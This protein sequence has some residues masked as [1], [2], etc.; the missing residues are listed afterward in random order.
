MQPVMPPGNRA[1]AWDGTDQTTALLFAVTCSVI[2]GHSDHEDN[3]ALCRNL[4]GHVL[5][6]L[7]VSPYILESC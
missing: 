6:H 3:D 4:A 5:H 1:K 7:P 2:I